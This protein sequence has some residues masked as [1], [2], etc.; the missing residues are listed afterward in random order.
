M[1]RERAA[2]PLARN[3]RGQD[4]IVGRVID[5]VG[6]SRDD[7]AGEHPC[8]GREETDGADGGRLEDEAGRQHGAAADAVDE[9]TDRRLA[10]AG[11]DVEN[12]HQET[13]RGVA[14]SQLIVQQREEGRQRHVIDVRQAVRGAHKPDHARVAPQGQ[15]GCH[16]AAARSAQ[17]VAVLARSAAT[18]A[19]C[20]FTPTKVNSATA[21]RPADR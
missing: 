7:D 9:K 10:E 20:V 13:E 19:T 21:M 18:G 2:E 14:E 17:A 12:R 3:V 4:R 8:V 16:L 5:G 15:N 1:K 11:G 6:K